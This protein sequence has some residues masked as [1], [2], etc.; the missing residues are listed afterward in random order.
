MKRIVNQ[1]FAAKLKDEDYVAKY[2][3]CQ[4]LLIK[5]TEVLTQ[6]WFASEVMSWKFIGSCWAVLK[7]IRWK[8][9]E[10]ATRKP[11]IT[12]TRRK[13][14]EEVLVVLV[15]SSALSQPQE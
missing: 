2:A 10:L 11:F 9:E 5:E 12:I 15:A 7:F 1:T 6:F 8:L 14:R 3:S 4:V 13:R